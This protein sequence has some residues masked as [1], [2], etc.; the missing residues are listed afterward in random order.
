MVISVLAA[1]FPIAAAR[2][3]PN[4]SVQSADVLLLFSFSRY[5]CHYRETPGRVDLSNRGC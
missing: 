5:G 4:K 1:L 2:S 3:P